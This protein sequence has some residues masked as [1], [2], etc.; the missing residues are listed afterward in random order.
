MELV[1]QTK[2]RLPVRPRMAMEEFKAQ[3]VHQIALFYCYVKIPDS[4]KHCNFHQEQCRRL[5]LKGRIRVSPEGINGVLSGLVYQLKDYEECLRKELQHT[6]LDQSND[7]NSKLVSE[8]EL[9]VKYCG[10]REDLP[11]AVQLFDNLVVNATKS[12]VSLVGTTDASDRKRSKSRR[13]RNNVPE[14]SAESSLARYTE[15]IYVKGLE[16][17][18]PATY[19]SPQEWEQ[20]LLQFNQDKGGSKAILLDCRNVYESNVGFFSAPKV[21]T[22]LTNT[23]KYSELPQVLVEQVDRL[24]KSDHIF[25]YCTGGVRCERASVFLQS[26]LAERSE[27]T[28]HIYQLHGGIQR[29]LESNSTE[30][31]LFKGKNFVFDPRRTDP[32]HGNQVVGQCLVCK[33][34]SSKVG[35]REIISHFF[36]FKV[37]H[38]MTTLTMVTRLVKTRKPGVGNVAF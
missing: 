32:V 5:S 13:R 27:N 12:V 4:H 29:Y 19:L 6:V 14:G 3:H 36:L 30:T 8:F 1:G 11:F 33:Y 17:V 2:I 26:L 15:K 28:H 34:V 37:I 24:A 16:T 20:R 18:Q 35:L 31:T 38:H 22:V 7:A 25:M 23:R 9:D 10:L 21:D